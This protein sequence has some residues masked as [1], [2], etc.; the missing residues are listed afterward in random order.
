M[1]KAKI[2]KTPE[3]TNNGKET[4]NTIADR[5]FNNPIVAILTALSDFA[6]RLDRLSL[7]TKFILLI[8]ALSI[9]VPISFGFA[10]RLIISAI[11]CKGG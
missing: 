9:V 11:T 7:S 3:T 2:L 1:E 4:K 6:E 5:N 8:L 10:V